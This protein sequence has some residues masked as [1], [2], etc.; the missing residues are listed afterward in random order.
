MVSEAVQGGVNLVQLREKDLSAKAL[1]ELAVGLRDISRGKALLFINDRIDVAIAC[2]A[3]GVQLGEESLP[4]KAARKIAGDNLLLGRSVH[5]VESAIFAESE[6]ADMLIT[7]TIF[8]TGSHPGGITSGLGLLNEVKKKV[9]IPFIAIGGIKV[10]NV[11]SVI[12][13]GASGAAVITAITR[14][15]DPAKSSQE[16]AQEMQH[17][18]KSTLKK[19]VASQP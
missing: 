14:S 8:P 18:W 1:Y 17:A 10:N 16:L 11:A 6:G 5:S 12:E 9:K 15:P 4:I 19:R 13:S 3:D 2:G 7:G